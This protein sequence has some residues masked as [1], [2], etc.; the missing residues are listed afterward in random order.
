MA[1]ISNMIVDDVSIA[2]TG[3][4]LR[5]TGV[6]GKGVTQLPRQLLWPGPL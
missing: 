4:T 2:E 6:P 3:V 5:N 1:R